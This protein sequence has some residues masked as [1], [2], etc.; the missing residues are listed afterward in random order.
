M[1][2]LD[3][4]ARLFAIYRS[5]KR[6]W[7]SLYYT[8]CYSIVAKCMGVE[9]GKGVR[10]NGPITIDRF[11]YSRIKIGDNVIL[12]SHRAFNPRGCQPCMLKTATDFAQIEIG[13]NS[14]ISGISIVAW[15]SVKIG[16]NVLIGS[17]SIIGDTDGHPERLGTQPSPVV[18]G[19]NV[20]IGMHTIVLKG[21]TIG[22]NAIIGA[23]SVV[24]K[25]IPANSVAAGV[26]CRVIRM[27]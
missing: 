1:K 9:L 20:F 14:G 24:N 22:D 15:Q 12:N 17:G 18:I 8:F 21:V 27:N 10:F 19:N 16:N 4:G 23:G 11:K 26:P 6:I 25:D 5:V 13:N 2:S 7:L 3:L